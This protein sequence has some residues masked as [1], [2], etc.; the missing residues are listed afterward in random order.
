[1]RQPRR[2]PGAPDMARSTEDGTAAMLK[3]CARAVLPGPILGLLRS[4]RIRRRLTR[5]PARNVHHRYGGFELDIHL[6]DALG[7]GWYD[8][9]DQELMEL[10]FLRRGRL[11]AGARCFDLGAHQCVVA[12]VLAKIVGPTGEV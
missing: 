2:G 1:M 10:Q 5:Y 9:D 8:H 6:A 7:E 4:W 12:V 11:R 3:K